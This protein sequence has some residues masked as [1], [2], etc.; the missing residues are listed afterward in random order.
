MKGDRTWTW[1]HHIHNDDFVIKSCDILWLIR[2][3]HDTPY[4]CFPSP[5]LERWWRYFWRATFIGAR[6]KEHSAQYFIALSSWNIQYN[7]F[8]IGCYVLLV[9]LFLYSLTSYK[10]Y[11]VGG[12]VYVID[13]PKSGWREME[14]DKCKTFHCPLGTLIRL[15]Y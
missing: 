12:S 11:H 14:G 15:I 6:N 13:L 7:S 9:Q 3:C 8:L 1:S 2:G 5:I 4:L 10:F